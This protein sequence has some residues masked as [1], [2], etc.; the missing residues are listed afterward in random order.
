MITA[1]ILSGNIFFQSTQHLYST[2]LALGFQLGHDYVVKYNAIPNEE[3]DLDSI[4]T[5]LDFDIEED[6]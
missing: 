5:L 1:A 4:E 6:K 3:V 2:A